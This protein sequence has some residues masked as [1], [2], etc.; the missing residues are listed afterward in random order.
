MEGPW[1]SRS[2]EHSKKQQLNTEELFW[3][4]L[5]K[6]IF[7][8]KF[9]TITLESEV[10]YGTGLDAMQDLSTYTIKKPEGV[11]DIKD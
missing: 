5:T 1:Q 3:R 2:E 7:T 9:V 8:E 4:P 6:R 10:L 11:F